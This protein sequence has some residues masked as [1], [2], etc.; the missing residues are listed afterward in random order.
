MHFKTQIRLNCSAMW[1]ANCS[2]PRFTV[3]V[4]TLWQWR[5]GKRIQLSCLTCSFVILSSAVFQQ[6]WRKWGY[7]ISTRR[8]RV[9]YLLWLN[10]RRTPSPFFEVIKLMCL[11]G[12]IGV[13]VSSWDLGHA[14]EYI[15]RN[16]QLD[17]DTVNAVS[18]VSSSSEY[19][20]NADSSSLTTNGDCWASSTSHPQHWAKE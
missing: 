10:M 13:T 8:L 15:S 4:H 7:V 11:V 18:K 14:S 9:N 6:V 19:K 2:Q 20:Q 1:V 3:V 17:P 12:S 5:C 16:N